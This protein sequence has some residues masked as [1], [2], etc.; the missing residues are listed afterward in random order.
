MT[1]KERMA[2]K[3]ARLYGGPILIPYVQW[4]L[5]ESCRL[6]IKKLFFV[7][8]DGYVLKQIADILIQNKKYDIRTAYMYGSRR[9]WRVGYFLQENLD[10][11]RFIE[12]SYREKITDIEKLA[13]VFLIGKEEL[14][15]YLP[16]YY[17]RHP[18]HWVIRDIF[19][20][21]SYLDHS[22]EFK[23]FLQEKHSDLGERVKGYLLQEVGEEVTASAFV[24]SVGTGFTQC[25]M[26]LF[27]NKKD[28][29]KTFYYYQHN[30]NGKKAFY[31]YKKEE[32]ESSILIE[33]LCRSCEGQTFDYRK[34]G[35]VYV[36][37]FKDKEGTYL[38]DYGYER[39]FNEIQTM[40]R[41]VG[42]KKPEEK[43][44]NWL[45]FS[46]MQDK[47]M[48]NYIGD[49]PYG[50]TGTEQ[51][52][53]TFAPKL[54]P[55]QIIHI[56]LRGRTCTEQRDYKGAMIDYS[57]QRTQGFTKKTIEFLEQTNIMKKIQ[58]WNAN[59][60]EKQWTGSIT[61]VFPGLIGK[62]VVVYGAGKI[63]KALVTDF[64]KGQGT[65][66]VLWIDQ[67]PGAR[68]PFP[69]SSPECIQKAEFDFVIIASVTWIFVKEIERK[70][71]EY[72]VGEEKIVGWM[73]G[74]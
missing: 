47:E 62:K 30:K 20:I 60:F 3:M 11:I 38:A 7:A 71:K 35:D 69:V 27:L 17:R 57:V 40:T 48:L 49:F 29:L 46:Q 50:V 12:E 41:E 26:G 66:L 44:E 51:T 37:V 36:P 73:L 16:A 74:K 9:V 59:T 65:K 61:K 42:D 25:G 72:G 45:R 5:T 10:I 32:K 24:E 34:E 13:S 70:L 2:K 19:F 43:K 39:Y 4:V 67:N 52:L 8:R 56:L 68:Q 23:R 28:E 55:L 63:G 14:E 15:K 54:T 22:P 18:N 21:Q 6:G 33:L 53:C 58:Q 64:L 31:S 1:E